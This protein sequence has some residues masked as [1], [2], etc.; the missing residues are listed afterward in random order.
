MNILYLEQERVL[1]KEK[2]NTGFS[3]QAKLLFIYDFFE[4]ILATQN[5]NLVGSYLPEFLSDYIHCLAS[6]TVCGMKAEVHKLLIKQ[7]EKIFETGFTT[8]HIA[9][10][11]IVKRL[12]DDF[13]KLQKI[14]NGKN[15]ETFEPKAYFPLLEE[16]AIKATGITIG[17]IESVT[18]KINKAK[19]ETKFIIVPSEKEIEEKITEQIKQSWQ[20]A[21][22]ISKKYVRKVHPYHEVIISFDNKAGFCKGNSLGTALT[23]SFIEEILKTYNS[24]VTI[25]VGE[26]IAFTGGMN[27]QGKISNTSFEIIKQKVELLFY[28]GMNLFIV[29]KDEEESA[30][31][32]LD[33]LKK[34]FP[35]RDLRIIGI[36]DINDLLNRR[37]IIEIKKQPI[38][39]RTGKFIKKNWAAVAVILFLSAIISFFVIRDIDTNPVSFV[40]D[41]SK[42]YIKN[43]SGKV[44]WD[45]DINVPKYLIGQPNFLKSTILIVDI[46]SDGVNEVVTARE[47]IK[48]EQ[49]SSDPNIKCYD[50]SGNIIWKYSFKDEVV[51]ELE[52]LN[53]E[54]SSLLCDTFTIN[55]EKSLFLISN[56]GNSFSSAISRIS[57]LDGRRQP[58][59]FWASGHIM[60]AFIKDIDSDS[61]PEIVGFGYDNGFEDIV[62]F[63][64]EIDTLTKVRPTTEKYLIRNYPIAD[65]K[66]YIRFPKTDYEIYHQ[67]RTPSLVT[68][69]F[70]D[71]EQ[72]R[73]Y[74]FGFAKNK[75][76]SEPTISFRIDYN[77]K[78]IDLVILS[79]YRVQRDTL[80]ARGILKPPYTDTKEYC[81][82]I[83]SKLLFYKNGK[84][85]KREELDVT[86]QN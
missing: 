67:T 28:S 37:N 53:T 32:K 45:K 44:L 49:I 43:K 24:P 13:E 5:Q 18:I 38:A 40:A 36:E 77:F 56:N 4:K 81:N 30:N 16:E 46:N 15:L 31:E 63:V 65:M 35:E 29:P 72:S 68:G 58:G 52:E 57:L 8:S 80:V 14:L 47:R 84:W 51:S 70:S 17:V 62:F 64:Y 74:T 3:N 79:S 71:E 34:E 12:K 41:G 86:S 76:N 11:G 50:Y 22:N 54:Y 25:K 61:K 82:L 27:E 2:L 42:I 6:W 73:K 7:A 23:L 78:D 55:G 21:I 59:T 48:D 85:V 69:S 60:G 75:D 20:N 83:K 1:L 26:G 66:A 33:D 9:F 39:V 10:E 19:N